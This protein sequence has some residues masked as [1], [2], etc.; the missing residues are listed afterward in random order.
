M[1]RTART[2][3]ASPDP[4]PRR[5]VAG[6][7][8]RMFAALLRAF[9][10]MDFRSQHFGRATATGPKALISP[11]FWV[12]GQYLIIGG[13]LSVTLFARVDAEAFALAGLATSMLVIF[14]S[15]IVEFHEVV[16][17]ADDL[18]VVA[19]HPV[20]VRDELFRNSAWA[21]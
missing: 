10:L 16:L 4:R 21:G 11:L 3:P 19:P 15:V 5:S 18:T 20:P 14:S 1:S 7:D 9:L 2:L 17:N 13:L 8:V 6:V 12:I